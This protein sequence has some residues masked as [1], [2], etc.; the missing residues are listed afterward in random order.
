MLP[1]TAGETFNEADTPVAGSLA[2]RVRT[3]AGEVVPDCAT[4]LPAD[5]TTINENVESRVTEYQ[6]DPARVSLAALL[7]EAVLQVLRWSLDPFG[8]SAVL[9]M[10]DRSGTA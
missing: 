9:P 7:E 8:G 3:G 2:D 6:S 10:S 5:P 1:Q 4:S